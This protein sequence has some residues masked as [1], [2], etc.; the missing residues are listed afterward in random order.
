TE[1]AAAIELKHVNLLEEVKELQ[2]EI[3]LIEGTLN[4][5][6]THIKTMRAA[7]PDIREPNLSGQ[8]DRFNHLLT[9]FEASIPGV[10][11]S[12]RNWNPQE[13]VSGYHAFTSF[14]LGKEWITN[15]F[16]QDWYGILPLF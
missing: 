10:I 12:L 6:A 1:Q 15:S 4:A 2:A 11:E 13:P 14:V 3:P 8:M 16:I 9:R 5:L 7:L